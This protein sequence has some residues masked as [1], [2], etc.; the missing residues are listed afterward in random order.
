M[1]FFFTLARKMKKDRIN[2]FNNVRF[3]SRLKFPLTLRATHVK[4]LHCTR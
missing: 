3:S 4:Q 1:N 2:V